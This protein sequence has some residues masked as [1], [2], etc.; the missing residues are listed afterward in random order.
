MKTRR[1]II[2]GACSA[3]LGAAAPHAQMPSGPA[4]SNVRV[5]SGVINPPDGKSDAQ[6]VKRP[7]GIDAEFVD[8]A[9]L[10]G[11]SEVQAG[12]LAGERSA[13]P[14]VR[15]FAKRMIDDHGRLNEALRRLAERKGLPVQAAQIIDPDVEALRGKNGRDF[16]VAY[17]AAAGPAAHRKAIRLF[18]DEARAGRDPD[19]RAFAAQTLPMLRRHLA[20]ARAVSHKVGA[21]R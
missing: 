5:G 13:T 20:D 2:A 4:E 17:L 3:A 18:E 1:W 10:A 8:K 15:A 14:D 21:A 9:A 19:L 7:Q 6:I 11:K 16:D 12:Q